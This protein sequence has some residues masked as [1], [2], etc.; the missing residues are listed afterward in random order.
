MKKAIHVSIILL[1]IALAALTFVS[2]TVYNRN[3][4]RVSAV[5][6]ATGLVPLTIADETAVTVPGAWRVLY[7]AEEGEA[8]KEGDVLFRFDTR[9]Y[10]LER[11]TLELDIRRLE[12][13]S[14]PLAAYERALLRDRLALLDRDAPPAQYLAPASGNTTCLTTAPGRYTVPGLPLLTLRSETVERG[15]SYPHVVPL[16]AVFYTGSQHPVVYAVH[17]RRGLFGPEDYIA[18]VSVTVI[19]EN[20]RFAAIE[21]EDEDI[22][23]AGLTLARDID[24]WVSDGDTVWVR[25]R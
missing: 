7:V 17:S 12:E 5:R 16:D 20:E 2:R 25:E 15:D 1:C 24:G 8:I 3:L 19:R 21:A 23:L 14:S 9:A 6:V 10:D 11:R 13:D 4:P 18:A 22:S